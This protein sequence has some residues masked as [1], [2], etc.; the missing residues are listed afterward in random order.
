MDM[1]WVLDSVSALK[2]VGET[3]VLDDQASLTIL[4][5]VPLPYAVITAFTAPGSAAEGET[6]TV[7]GTIQNQGDAAGYCLIIINDE[8]G[9]LIVPDQYE[10]LEVGGSMTRSGDS[11]MPAEDYS[12]YCWA[13]HWED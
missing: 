12:V 9:N 3:W 11:V 2:R 1:G 8:F 7:S 5:E 13:Y 10:W 4:L 6:V